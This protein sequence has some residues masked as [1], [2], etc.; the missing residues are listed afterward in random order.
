VKGYYRESTQIDL[1]DF[2]ITELA[3]IFGRFKR[4]VFK[5]EIRWKFCKRTCWLKH[6][7]HG[8]W[9]MEFRCTSTEAKS[10]GCWAPTEQAKRLRFE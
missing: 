1:N 6:I 5:E 9:S 4:M 3:A 7:A 8:E 10:S 2:G